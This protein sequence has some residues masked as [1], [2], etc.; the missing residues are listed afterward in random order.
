MLHAKNLRIAHVA[1]TPPLAHRYETAA[2][3]RFRVLVRACFKTQEE[4]ATYL[5]VGL[6]SV[7]RWVRAKAR[8]PGWTLLALEER[9][10]E[11]RVEVAGRKAA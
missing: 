7:S 8:I 4:C 9:A 2:R 10:R 11:C 5:G 3:L 1:A 6:R